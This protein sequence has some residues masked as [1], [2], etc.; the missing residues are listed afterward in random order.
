M[1]NEKI[2]KL[3][4]YALTAKTA[5]YNED[6]MTAIELAGVT[7]CKVNECIEAINMML[8]I[9]ETLEQGI[10]INYDANTENL[11]IG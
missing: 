6:A 5:I 11:N 2:T 1:L 9:I 4:A 3:R 8:D 10:S 7:A